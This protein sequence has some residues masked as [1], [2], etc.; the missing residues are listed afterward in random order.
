MCSDQIAR[1]RALGRADLS[2]QEAL[3]GDGFNDVDPIASAR[4]RCQS[5]RQR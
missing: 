1:S 3:R 5:K 2:S 4:S